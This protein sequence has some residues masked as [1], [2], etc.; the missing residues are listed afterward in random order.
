MTSYLTL[1]CFFSLSYHDLRPHHRLTSYLALVCFLSYHDPD[2]TTSR[3]YPSSS[4]RL[5]FPYASNDRGGH[6]IQ[7]TSTTR[8]DLST[9]DVK[10]PHSQ[11]ITPTQK[12]RKEPNIKER[13]HCLT[14]LKWKFWNT[15]TN[16]VSCASLSTRSLQPPSITSTANLLRCFRII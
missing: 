11:T 8:A 1:T 10:D 15:L 12:C 9:T 14:E 3:K 13:S 4:S 6:R 2:F 7:S 16:I 5:H